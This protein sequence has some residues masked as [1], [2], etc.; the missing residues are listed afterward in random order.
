MGFAHSRDVHRSL[1]SNCKCC[2]IDTNMIRI[3]NSLG[4]DQSQQCVVARVPWS[5][6]PRQSLET[7]K[8]TA[9]FD[10]HLEEP[11]EFFFNCV[12]MMN[13]LETKL[14]EPETKL[15]STEISRECLMAIVIYMYDNRQSQCSNIWDSKC[16]ALIAQMVRA[17][18]MNPKVGGE[19]PSQAETF[20]VS[21]TLPLSQ[22]RPFV[23]RKWML[24]PAHS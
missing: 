16:L 21:K 15:M 8:K 9:I 3:S 24:L 12:K 13:I 19:S 10:N 14:I 22:E 17:F 5:G 7:H 1:K 23:C 4:T 11:A 20:S 6:I 18:G 2:N